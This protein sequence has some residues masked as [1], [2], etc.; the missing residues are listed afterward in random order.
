MF[1]SMFFFP[2]MATGM[3][4]YMIIGVLLFAFWIWMIVD[5]V[6]RRFKNKVEKVIWVV[7]SVLGGWVGA[8]R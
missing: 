5:C 3:L 1:D 7:I 8:L 2:F 6:Q 4:L